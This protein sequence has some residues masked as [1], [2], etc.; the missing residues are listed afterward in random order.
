MNLDDYGNFLRI[1]VKEDIS[2]ALVTYFEFVKPSGLL[3]TKPAAVN[4]AD[5]GRY[6]GNQYGEY[7]VEQGFLDEE[8][9]WTVRF[10]VEFAGSQKSSKT[11]GFE[12]EG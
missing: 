3:V 7:L 6:L 1:G 4:A 12:I 8:G 5:I 2:S 9:Y 11:L 10:V